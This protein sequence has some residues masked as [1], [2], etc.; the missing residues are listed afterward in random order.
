[1]NALAMSDVV[2]RQ[3]GG[4]AARGKTNGTGLKGGQLRIVSLNHFI[5]QMYAL[6]IRWSETIVNVSFNAD[7]DTNATQDRES[8]V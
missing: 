6:I 7:M 5:Y 3:S 1:V 2:K 8:G 4:H